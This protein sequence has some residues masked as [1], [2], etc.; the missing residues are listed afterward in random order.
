M[1]FLY[2]IALVLMLSVSA[3]AGDWIRGSPRVIDGNTL[4]I[5]G[6]TIVL[7]GIEKIDSRRLCDKGGHRFPCHTLAVSALGRMVSNQTVL[8]ET[9][10][11]STSASLIGRCIVDNIELA[12]EL[13]KE[14]LA[15]VDEDAVIPERIDTVGTAPE[16]V[17][18]ARGGP[19]ETLATPAPPAAEPEAETLPPGTRSADPE[20]APTRA[21]AAPTM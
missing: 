7:H 5:D 1:A 16:G 11:G 19:A 10:E 12:E 9:F 20:P 18:G 6:Q 3:V 8:C 13:V 15:E 14:G 4:S 21:P 2:A 17:G